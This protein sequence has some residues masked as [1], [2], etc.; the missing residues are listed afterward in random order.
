MLFF[1]LFHRKNICLDEASQSKT[2]VLLKISQ[3]IHQNNPKLSIESLFDAFWKRETLGSTAI[4][5]GI[6][7][8]HIRSQAAEETQACFLKLKTPIDFGAEDKQ[9]IDLVIGLVVPQTNTTQHLALLNGICQEFGKP[10]LRNACRAAN[11][12]EELFRLLVKPSK[13]ATQL[14][15]TEM[16]SE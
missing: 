1:N 4:G 11:D 13:T 10:S 9:P 7:I 2:A 14:I 15:E 6:I 3:L 8:P 5:H 12:E 16:I